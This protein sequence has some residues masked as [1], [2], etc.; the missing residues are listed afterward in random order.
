MNC[1]II[2]GKIIEWQ[3]DLKLFCHSMILPKAV[4]ALARNPSDYLT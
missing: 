4:D 3:N 1:K 2:S